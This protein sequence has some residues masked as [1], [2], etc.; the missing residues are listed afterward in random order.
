M[1][2]PSP[3]RKSFVTKFLLDQQFFWPKILWTKIF[4]TN[5]FF[6]DQQFCRTNSFFWTK[7]VFWAKHFLNETFFWTNR[8][9]L[10]NIFLNEKIFPD[11]KFFWAKILFRTNYFLGGPKTFFWQNF[12]FGPKIFWTKVFFGLKLFLGQKFLE[13]KCIV[14]QKVF[15]DHNFFLP[16]SLCATFQTLEPPLLWKIRW[17]FL[18]LFLLF[19]KV[20]STPSPR[21]KSGVWQNL[22]S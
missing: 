3:P 10:T 21:P 6:S 17:G 18:L 9:F 8:Y 12:S 20:M 19:E 5:N 13:S 7:N 16:N 22:G 15:A 14:N 1:I 2:P 11:Q 4:Q